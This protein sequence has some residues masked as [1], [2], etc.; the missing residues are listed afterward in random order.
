VARTPLPEE[1]LKIANVINSCVGIIT[2]TAI[3]TAVGKIKGIL[4]AVIMT[5]GILI[6]KILGNALMNIG[7]YFGMNGF[8]GLCLLAVFAFAGGVLGTALKR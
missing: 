1:V 7:G 8:I 6:I 2:G 5:L 4:S 3:M